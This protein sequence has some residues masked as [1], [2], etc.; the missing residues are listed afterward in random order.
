LWRRVDVDL[1]HAGVG[2]DLQQLQARIARRR[3]A[4]QHDL[5]AQFGG[6]G[7]D[8]GQQV[9]VVF[10][11]ASGGMKTYITPWDA[12]GL[13]LRAVGAPRI[14]HLHTQRGAGDPVGRLRWRPAATQRARAG[15][16]TVALSTR[17]PAWRLR[18]GPFGPHAGSIPAVAAIHCG[19]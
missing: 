3:V 17:P 8:G 9:Q 14:A 15:A 10:Q 13:G 18:G 5:H 16:L 6:G 7:L 2:R 1:D 4:F 12:H 11:R 19:P